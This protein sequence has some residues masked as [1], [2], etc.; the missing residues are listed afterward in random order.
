[1]A[2]NPSADPTGRLWP[3][4]AGC[5]IRFCISHR[6]FL[7]RPLGWTHAQFIRLAFYIAAGHL[8]EQPSIVAGRANSREATIAERIQS[9]NSE[10][11]TNRRR[12]P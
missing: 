2:V 7:G 6:H 9:N 8:L 10:G 3:I 11:I 5:S 4:F 12:F 1:M